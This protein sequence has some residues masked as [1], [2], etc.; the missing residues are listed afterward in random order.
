MI[1]SYN[2]DLSNL[3]EPTASLRIV[4]TDYVQENIPCIPFKS[5]NPHSYQDFIN[6]CY[7]DYFRVYKPADTGLLSATPH[8]VPG[9]EMLDGVSVPARVDTLGEGIVGVQSYGTLL[10]IPT[11]SSLET[12]FQF[13]LPSKVAQAS[14]DHKTM[15]YTLHVQKQPGTLAIP[16]SIC[17]RLPIGARVVK[18]SMGGKYDLGQWCMDG[19]LITDIHVTLTFTPP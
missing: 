7:W 10:I 8:A 6:L 11:G 15:V 3:D 17:V 13:A 18:A 5:I 16:I 9:G 19:N 1:Y 4:Q 2:I 12:D 14:G